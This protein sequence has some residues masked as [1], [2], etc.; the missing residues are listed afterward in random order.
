MQ[1]TVT[2]VAAWSKNRKITLITEKFDMT[3]FTS[4]LYE[5][6]WQPTIHLE[7]QPLGFSSLPKLLEI[8]LDRA[9]SFTDLKTVR[10]EERPTFKIY[11]ALHLSVLMYGA[12]TWKPWLAAVRLEQ[13]ERC[14]NHTLCVLT[15]QLLT[16]P[17]EIAIAFEKAARLPSGRPRRW[18]PNSP[19]VTAWSDPAGDRPSKP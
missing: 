2:R 1:N 4:N 18:I 14:Q 11:K 15:G 16:A 10:L 6:R 8:T 13:L 19:S 9:L 17:V 5:A 7:G 3:F 12:H